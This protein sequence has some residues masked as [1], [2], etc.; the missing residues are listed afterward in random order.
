LAGIPRAVR[1]DNRLRM[2]RS[3]PITAVTRGPIHIIALTVEINPR[4]INAAITLPPGRAEDVR[5]GNQSDLLFAD[6]F[7]GGRCSEKDRIHANVEHDYNQ[8]PER[9]GQRN[10]PAWITNFSR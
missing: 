6:H 9:E 8:C 3:S 10:V 1:R 2:P 5:A 4:Q 7:S